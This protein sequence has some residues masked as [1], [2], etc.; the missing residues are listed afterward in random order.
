MRTAIERLIDAIIRVGALYDVQ[1]D[2]YSIRT[3][4][5]QEYERKV[6]FDDSI[7]QDRQ[8]NINEGILLTGN[9][10]MSKKRFLIETLGMTEAEADAEL[11][12]IRAESPVGGAAVDFLNVGGTE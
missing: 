8:T 1:Y 9:G 7:L 2:G 11:A 4:A 6:T 3:L 10:L 12:A 5:A